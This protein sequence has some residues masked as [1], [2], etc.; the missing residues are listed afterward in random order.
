MFR[1]FRRRVNECAGGVVGVARRRWKAR[2]EGCLL[3]PLLVAANEG[4]R[5]T[6]WMYVWVGVWQVSGR[7]VVC[8][9]SLK[10]RWSDQ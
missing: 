9:S 6:A 5:T 7:G 4:Y 1:M 10:V 2:W 8:C 3:E